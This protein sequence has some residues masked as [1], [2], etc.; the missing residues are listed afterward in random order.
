MTVMKPHMKNRLASRVSADF[1]VL[2]I[3][4]L[5]LAGREDTGDTM[6]C[7]E[8]AVELSEYS[9]G[10]GPASNRPSIAVQL[11]SVPSRTAIEGLLLR[12]PLACPPNEFR[13]R[14][15]RGRR[16]ILYPIAKLTDFTA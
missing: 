2:V 8:G 13:R 1:W 4:A 10:P 12:Q 7:S 14:I 15:T 3:P 11:R 9:P 5:W 16:L 6:N